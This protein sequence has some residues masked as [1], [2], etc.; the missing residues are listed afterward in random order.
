MCFN[1]SVAIMNRLL[2][3]YIKEVVPALKKEFG[4]KNNLEVPK[5]EKVVLNS[6]VGRVAKDEKMVDWVEK[7]LTKI[8]GQKAVPSKAKKA[9]ASFKT[10]QGMNIGVRVTLR[11]DKMY[12]FMDR[13]I[14]LALPRTRDFR[15]I[16]KKN[17]DQNGNLHVGVKED[18]IFPEVSHERAGNI[19]GFQVSMVTNCGDK[20]AAEKLFSLMGFPIKK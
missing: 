11:K 13:F 1:F 3:K 18:I 4:Y 17:V 5:I 19:F 20:A 2:E 7:N 9:I 16:D 15:G 6:G 12:E 10:R 14:S 8:A